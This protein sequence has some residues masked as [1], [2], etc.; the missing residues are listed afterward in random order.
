MTVPTC[1]AH[2]L[3]L[4]ILQVLDLGVDLLD[5]LL[6]KGRQLLALLDQRRE[7][8]LR[9]GHQVCHVQL[10]QVAACAC[11]QTSLLN[12]ALQAG[13][14]GLGTGGM[15]L[16]LQIQLGTAGEPEVFS[17][18]SGMLGPALTGAHYCMSRAQVASACKSVQ[19]P[20]RMARHGSMMAQILMLCNDDHGHTTAQQ[21]L[22][23]CISAVTPC[24]RGPA[25]YGQ[26]L[27]S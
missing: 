27:A 19:F 1:A 11:K 25:R 23:S 12:A 9:L 17:S 14:N 10:W 20:C 8:R 5:P 18:Y 15:Q 22:S 7:A 24:I 6:R 3:H 2:A 26:G 4:F 13:V 21:G 16:S